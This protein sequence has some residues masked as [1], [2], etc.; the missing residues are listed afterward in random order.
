MKT[1]RESQF[2][3]W[4]ES[5]GMGL[6][7]RYP[8]CAVLSF[9]PD[10]DLSRFWCVPREPERRPHFLRIMLELM[11]DWESCFAWRHMGSWPSA[12]DP[13]RVNE[14]VEVQILSGL[15]LPMDTA[16][17]VEFDRVERRQLVT[18]LFVTTVFGWSVGEDLYVVPDHGRFI[19]KASHHHVVHADFREE[20]SLREFVGGMAEARFD[21]PD[22]VP[23]STFLKPSW[24]G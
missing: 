24:M 16:N 20:S 4:A 23:D 2:L 14:E 17:I 8:D 12:T 22:Q 13:D 10:P 9:Q 3:K 1:Y 11:S 19:M 15:G 5:R 6:D 7:E 18:L 21:L